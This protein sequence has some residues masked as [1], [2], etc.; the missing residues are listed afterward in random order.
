ML[1]L[2]CG[3]GRLTIPIAQS[4]V[5]IVGLD[6]SP[7][8][9]AHARTKAAAAEVEIQFVEGDCRSFA[10]PR[11]FALIF[12][13]FN[14]MQHLH[15]QASLA[16]LFG[17]VRKHLAPEGKFIFDVF[18][19]KIALLARSGGE[20]LPERQYGAS[21]RGSRH[22]DRTKRPLGLAAQPHRLASVDLAP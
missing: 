16:G 13:A 22:R 14:S 12:M 6:L 4:D 7:S 3:T 2:A 10:L 9:L 15:D 8:M 17:S 19:P 1:E 21:R 18:N 20:R 5:E 11:K